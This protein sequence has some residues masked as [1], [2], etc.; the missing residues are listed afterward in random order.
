MKLNAPIFALKRQ[1]K[2]I[3]RI[4]GI[5]LHQALDR[6]AR[7]NGFNSWSHLASA[8]AELRPASRILASLSPGDLILLG[9][10]PGQGK[11]LLGLELSMLA[12]TIDRRGLFFSLD[13]TEA[14]ID[15]RL[16]ALSPGNKMKADAP[17]IDISDEI[18]ADYIVARLGDRADK[19]LIV[20]DYLQ[21]LD[22]R[23]SQPELA[24]QVEQLKAF[25]KRS[26]AIIV[27]I[28]QIDRAFEKSG[29]A[30]PDLSDVRLPNPL[31][32]NLFDRACFL[33]KGEVQMSKAA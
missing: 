10:R 12:G 14:D 32:L 3:A 15:E 31:D 9:A 23:R 4:E 19:A 26:G 8:H 29:K 1:A 30:L 2:T 28:S 20:I 16:A 21:L 27:L 33:H 18:C 5:R 6:V 11:T 25:A 24:E 17:L 13:Y 22:Q 7:E